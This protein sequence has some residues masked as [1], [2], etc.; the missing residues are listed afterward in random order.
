MPFYRRSLP[1]NE[2]HDCQL[3]EW[4]SGVLYRTGPGTYSIPTTES[5]KKSF[6]IRHWFDGLSLH[7]RFEIKDGQVT[8]RSK[9]GATA[10]EEY[11]R[12]T[13]NYPPGAHFGFLYSSE[14][15]PIQAEVSDKRIHASRSSEGSL[16]SLP[17]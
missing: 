9:H 15:N 2:C 5:G 4:L 17:I 14:I 10:A 13:G 6:E 1:G 11:I 8:Y 16:V 3:P 7:H 12:R